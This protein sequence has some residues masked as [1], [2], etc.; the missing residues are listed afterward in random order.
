MHTC[1]LA[2]QNFFVFPRVWLVSGFSGSLSTGDLVGLLV[3]GGGGGFG[4]RCLSYFRCRAHIMDYWGMGIWMR[5]WDSDGATPGSEGWV[6]DCVV[7][8]TT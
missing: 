7:L 5:I 4:D 2:W 6:C 3:V 1:L 8:P